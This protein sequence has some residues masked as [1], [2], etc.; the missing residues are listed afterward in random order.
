MCNHD[1]IIYRFW[2]HGSKNILN[3]TTLKEYPW[4]QLMTR[5]HVVHFDQECIP[6]CWTHLQTREFDYEQELFIVDRAFPVFKKNNLVPYSLC[7][8]MILVHSEFNSSMVKKLE[9]QNYIPVH[10]FSHGIIARDWYRYA[11]HDPALQQPRQ[12]GDRKFLIYNRAWTG[13]RE[14]RLKFAAMLAQSN[15]ADQCQMTLS[16]VDNNRYYKTYRAI[17]SHWQVD[18]I[19]LEDFF[20]PCGADSAASAD[21]N[22]QDYAKKIIEVVLET[23]FDEDRIS[24]TE[25]SLRPI[26]TKTPFI[27][28]GPAGSLQY[29]R[30]YGFQTFSPWIDESYDNEPDPVKRLTMIVKELER[31]A[32][33][34]TEEFETVW[35]QCSRIA[36]ANCCHFFSG[37]FENAVLEEYQ[38]GIDQAVE[39]SR[40][41]INT[42][43]WLQVKQ[44]HT[45]EQQREITEFLHHASTRT[46]NKYTV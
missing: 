23:I 32:A 40:D 39:Q 7:G 3:C 37:N 34:P 31:L 22:Q 19:D 24:L 20:E 6:E 8:K 4:F 29:L 2:P 42:G 13:S 21:Y 25:K 30:R 44:R 15:L 33:M 1:V 26:A 17:R 14:Y 11:E 18:S 27:L 5:P 16:F 35:D 43:A 38:Q 46:S 10:W 28:A 36:E 12:L 45:P 41:Y 9:A